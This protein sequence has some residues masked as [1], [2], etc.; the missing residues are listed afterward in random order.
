MSVIKL[1]AVLG[2][3]LAEI[4]AVNAHPL[5]KHV[6]Q[7]GR[8]QEILLTQPQFLAAF[9]GVVGVEHHRDVFR[10]VLGAHRFGVTPRIKILEVK[11]IGRRRRPQAQSVDRAIAVARDW[12]IVRHRQHVVSIQP[13]PAHFAIG[14][15]K[16][17][18]AP[19]ELDPLGVLRTLQFPQVAAAQP[20]IRLFNLV[21]V[22]DALA[23]HAIGV[24]NAVAHHGQ[25]Q[26]GAT[27]HEAGGQ[28]SQTAVA[29]ASVVL[30]FSEFFQSQTQIIERL[31]D[32]L[33][34]AQIEHGVAE[35]APH[36][37]LH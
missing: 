14:F 36:Q 13:A 9:G 18:G 26:R 16:A 37:E 22:L 10:H 30:T 3:E 15:D 7:A 20:V 17:L 11:F 2:G 8:S 25:P 1:E 4:L 35:G 34:H 33:G 24:T 5:P 27:V 23:E 32:R 21:A 28:P 12:Q 19:T 31:A 29:Q 6:L